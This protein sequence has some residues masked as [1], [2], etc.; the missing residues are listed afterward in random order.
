MGRTWGD[1]ARLPSAVPGVPSRGPGTPPMRAQSWSRSRAVGLC[2]RPQPAVPAGRRRG[3]QPLV[4]RSFPG[5]AWGLAEVARS[6]N[7]PQAGRGEWS[8]P[9]PDGSG[10][11][12]APREARGRK[13]VGEGPA[14]LRQS[15]SPFPFGRSD[16]VGAAGQRGAAVPLG[17][18]PP[19][20]P[21]ARG[22]GAG[23]G[24]APP[25]LAGAVQAL[26][27]PKP[28]TRDTATLTSSGQTL[29]EA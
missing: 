4:P 27:Y 2:H 10:P 21:R 18:S 26:A 19:S 24:A 3:H 6:T 14:A 29:T 22:V 17:P 12:A 16:V 8:L 9:G 28:V 1:R 25:G 11:G 15:P 20:P 5:A 23:A 7:P 13:G